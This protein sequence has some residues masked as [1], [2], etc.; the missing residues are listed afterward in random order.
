M[1][2]FIFQKI[3]QDE[4]DNNFYV[5]SSATSTEEIGNG[6]YPNAKRELEKHGIEAS[7][8][9]AKRLKK[10]D[11]E[12]YDLFICMENSN[13]NNVLRIIGE[14]R[15]NK[16]YK[17]LDFTDEKGDIEDPWYTGRFEKVY[18]EI[19]HG[20]KALY[21]YLKRKENIDEIL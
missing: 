18:N 12:K 9:I 2:K 13:I 7:N 1:A 8:H 14:D 20:C 17:L 10:E 11:Y 5:D 4:N 3:L 15:E 6:I 16:V 21:E 19:Y